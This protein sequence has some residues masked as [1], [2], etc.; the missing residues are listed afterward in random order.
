MAKASASGRINPKAAAMLTML[1]DRFDTRFYL[2]R[3][4]CYVTTET[5]YVA[6]SRDTLSDV[7]KTIKT[8]AV[9]EK[10]NGVE[11]NALGEMKA[12]LIRDLDE[13][14]NY[15]IETRLA[16]LKANDEE[17]I[18]RSYA[19][20]CDHDELSI[21]ANTLVDLAVELPKSWGERSD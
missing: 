7:E 9:A 16:S 3:M 20:R 2:S 17:Y 15:L 10:P 1:Y 12:R 18:A 21:V 13:M 6:K 8:L 19:E 4:T 11:A 14:Q 5:P